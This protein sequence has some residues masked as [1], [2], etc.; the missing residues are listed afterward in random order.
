MT[1]PLTLV[2]ALPF[3]S[4]AGMTY[5]SNGASDWITSDWISGCFEDHDL[6]AD[7]RGDG[8]T[9]RVYWNGRP[10]QTWT[11]PTYGGRK[12]CVQD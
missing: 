3:V 8:S 11:P 12:I 7:P 1:P 10:I 4:F 9:N 2:T 6:V 5:T